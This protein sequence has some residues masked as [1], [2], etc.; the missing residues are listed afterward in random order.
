MAVPPFAAGVGLPPPPL[1]PPLPPSSH[2]PIPS[3]SVP[4][5]SSITTL[6]KL[7]PTTLV[8]THIPPFLRHPRNLRDL[9]YY[10]T[11]TTTIKHLFYSCPIKR[12]A[13]DVNAK[14][15]KNDKAIAIIKFTHAG[16]A[17]SI[18]RNWKSVQQRLNQ[19]V[20][21]SLCN[22][23]QEEKEEGEGNEKNELSLCKMNAFILYAD[24]NL[25]QLHPEKSKV[26]A[27]MIESVWELIHKQRDSTTD[28]G[29]VAQQADENMIHSLVDA[30]RMIER[31]QKE[32]DAAAIK[33]GDNAI[34]YPD[35][36]SSGNYNDENGSSEA[37]NP[38]DST[39]KLDS[40]KVRAAA[41]GGAYDEENDPLNKP[42]VLEAVKQFK[43][44]LEITQGGF[45][46]K[47]REY[48]DKRL[49]DMVKKA[50]EK[51]KEQRRIEKEERE[52][53]SLLPPPPPPPPS[54]MMNLP[55]PPPPPLPLPPGGLPPQQLQSDNNIASRDTGRR[56]VSNLPAWMTAAENKKKEDSDSNNNN[57]G[58]KRSVDEVT[59]DEAANDNNEP[60][61][62]K[63]FIPSE[64]NRDINIRRERLDVTNE[65]TTSLAAI[66]A[67]NEAADKAKR[68]KEEQ[69]KILQYCQEA[70]SFSNEQILNNVYPKL[71]LPE[72]KPII[73]KFVKDQ[74]IEYL[75]EE[76]ATL[77][78]FVM[79]YLVK[80]N[81]TSNVDTI[82]VGM[83][84]TVQG[85]LEEMEVVLEEDAETFVID[86]FKKILDVTK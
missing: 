78:D 37:A 3:N 29:K 23:E 49:E 61:R 71:Y 65:G 83:G 4:S 59:N 35:L 60:M 56:G 32:L 86:L 41:G 48:V 46:R 20:K 34:N 79:N 16:N 31:R 85:L 64:A 63:T 77:I 72:T 74:M 30:Y 15:D 22:N 51:L 76:E 82:T 18:G 73:R 42:E 27:N 11:T 38:S 39:I 2:Q 52:K 7:N 36:D 66:R 54:L 55:P 33:N 8:L 50:K 40:A 1:P 58:K 67:A 43:K 13:N 17:L 84:K 26:D 69:E 24:S 47:R 21:E 19:Q 68:E 14:D 81:D 45:R 57:E 6:S 28:T 62:K 25:T 9:L 12:F 80:H 75:G 44:R 53:L 5:S 70:K 10:S